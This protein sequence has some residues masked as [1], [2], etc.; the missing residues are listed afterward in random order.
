MKAA[1]IVIIN[2]SSIAGRGVY[3]VARD[4][5]RNV[6]LPFVY[7]GRRV[8]RACCARRQWLPPWLTLLA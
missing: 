8:N 4:I 2:E 6:T 5:E 7:P 1:A 3:A